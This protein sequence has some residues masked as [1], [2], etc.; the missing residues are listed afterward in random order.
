MQNKR[1]ISQALSQGRAGVS[2]RRA[3]VFDVFGLSRVLVRSITRL[4]E[5]DHGNQPD[6]IAAWTAN[7]DPQSVR[8]WIAS[9]AQIWMAERSGQAVAVGGLRAPAEISLLYVDPGH[10]GQRVGAALL[11]RLEA[12]L[13]LSGA[14]TGHLMSTRTALGFY[15]RNGWVAAGEPADWNGIP[16]FPLRK[17]LHPS[18]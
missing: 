17:S 13:A 6:K 4:C 5:A 12:E 9:G 11:S 14:T 15:R 3:T 1:G 2:L 18:G 16:Q 8:N 7:K 10:A